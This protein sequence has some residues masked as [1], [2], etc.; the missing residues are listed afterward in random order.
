MS[1]FYINTSKFLMQNFLPSL[2]I[3]TYSFIYPMYEK[4]NLVPYRFLDY[5]FIMIVKNAFW[6]IFTCHFIFD[7]FTKQRIL[8]I[9]HNIKHKT[10]TS[11]LTYF[12]LDFSRF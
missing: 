11:G 1:D 7:L 12:C 4:W 10:T 2:I 8:K 5:A 3:S 9:F 6:E